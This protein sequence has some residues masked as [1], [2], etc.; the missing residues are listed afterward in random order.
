[1]LTTSPEAP[2]NL[3]EP[4]WQLEERL[5]EEFVAFTPGVAGDLAVTAPGS[6]LFRAA[7]ST[8]WQ[9]TDARQIAEWHQVMETNWGWVLQTDGATLR[10][11]DGSTW[12]EV[13]RTPSGASLSP[14]DGDVISASWS[15]GEVAVVGEQAVTPLPPVGVDSTV[16]YVEGVGVVAVGF[17]GPEPVLRVLVDGEW[18]P[19]LFDSLPGWPS[20][21]FDRLFVNSNDA[22][23]VVVLDPSSGEFLPVDGPVDRGQIFAPD[24]RSVVWAAPV[25]GMFVADES[26]RWHRVTFDPAAG[27]VERVASVTLIDGTVIVTARDVPERFSSGTISVYSRPLGDMP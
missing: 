14:F 7:G 15:G 21:G 13:A 1:M 6:L 16:G 3:P 12:E 8:D 18:Q 17:S 5:P 23:E 10:S 22:R 4:E 20:F 25:G 2:F 9:E 19:L 24:M 11:T 27:M 26:L